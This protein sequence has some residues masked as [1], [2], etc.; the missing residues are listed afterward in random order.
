MMKRTIAVLLALV[1]C[2]LS[3]PLSVFAQ[4]EVYD[5]SEEDK[6]FIYNKYI[7]NESMLEALFN[8]EATVGYWSMI[9]NIEKDK[10]LSWVIGEVSQIIKEYPD[11]QD[12]VEILT[13]LMI[14]QSGSLAE[15]IQKQSQFDNLKIGSDYG[16]DIIDIA[17]SFVG[18]AHLL[19]DVSNIIDAVADGTELVIENSEQ[20]KYYE[21]SIRDY[22]QSKMFLEA[23]NKYAKNRELKNAASSLI[24]ANDRLF[25]KRME[26]LSDSMLSVASYSAKLFHENFSFSLI[27]DSDIYKTDNTVKWY[28]DCGEKLIGSLKSIYAAGDFSFNLV[29]LA[30]NLGF[31]TTDTFKRYWEMK[32]VSDIARAVVEA[33][34][35]IKVPSSYNSPGAL[36]VI[37]TK[38]DYYKM[39]IATHARGEYLIYQLLIKD[40]GALSD[41]HVIQDFFKKQGETTDS[42]YNS[43][44]DIMI[45]YSDI[46]E[47]MFVLPEENSKPLNVGEIPKDAVEFDGHFYYVYELESI[48]SWDEA[49]QYCEEKGGYLATI[50]S[51]EEDEFVYSYLKDSFDYESAYFG[52]T[53]KNE[54]GIWE[55]D[56]GE[57]S[58]YTNWHSGEPNNENPNENYAMYYYKYSNGSWNDGDFGDRT[59]NND[60]SFICEW[61]PYQVP[62]DD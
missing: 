43:Q 20:A 1:M 57:V 28:V 54:E 19:E 55:W 45:K 16:K 11:K 30:G 37:Q 41:S 17:K 2:L 15:Q 59:L 21:M 50:T 62:E 26:Y 22:S 8:D 7:T 47:N 29:M 48:S 40:A 60:K 27:K 32:I 58:T 53:D 4:K 6:E 36:N 33:N 38:C 23:I 56:N 13:N 25:Q 51:Q 39:V 24:T 14:I 52:F 18:G 12:Y 61:G 31:G 42:W 10:F 3:F 49:K 9:H 34:N 44:V 35:S 46:L 5:Y